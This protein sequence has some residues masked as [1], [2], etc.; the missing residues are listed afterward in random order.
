M[1]PEP[2]IASTPTAPSA[3]DPR[4]GATQRRGLAARVATAAVFM[5]A[6]ATGLNAAVPFGG[7]AVSAFDVLTLLLLLD[8]AVTAA[9]GPIPAN[10]GIIAC[11]C[12]LFVLAHLLPP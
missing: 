10:H 5:V 8:F 1:A 9:R 3:P 4:A 7:G 12:V 6:A 2:A 11:T